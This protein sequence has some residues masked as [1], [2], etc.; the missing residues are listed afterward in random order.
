MAGGGKQAPEVTVT[1]CVGSSCHVKGSRRVI[2]G[3][4]ALLKKHAMEERVELKGSFCM[5]R[6]GKGVNWKINETPITSA[7]TDEAVT[8][9]RERVIE[10][11]I[12]GAAPE[13][14]AGATEAEPD[15]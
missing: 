5:E 11:L 7:T 3:F 14:P 9:F 12:R 8:E 10:R 1:V 15:E 6:C 4:S 2:N 13:L